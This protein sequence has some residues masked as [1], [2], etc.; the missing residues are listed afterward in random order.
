MYRFKFPL[1]DWSDDGHGK[2]DWYIVEC[3]KSIEDVQKA[4]NR[5]IKLYP[6]VNPEKY[7]SEYKDS[8][9]PR[10]IVEKLYNLGFKVV[11]TD[12][13]DEA[14]EQFYRE[15][16]VDTFADIVVWYL[17]LGDPEL[18]AKI[19][20]DDTPRLYIDVGYGLYY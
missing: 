20:E 12:N 13:I 10:D 15:F 8:S 5:A 16:W 1:G 14:I 3:A 18:Q 11:E 2:C 17:N 9:I 6:E 7:C 19:V 4:W